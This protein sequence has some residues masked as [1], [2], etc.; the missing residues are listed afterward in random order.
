MIFN[1]DDKR[2]RSTRLFDIGCRT[3]SSKDNRM[4]PKA[5]HV[6][7]C[8]SLATLPLPTRATIKCLIVLIPDIQLL[9]F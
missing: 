3:K 2:A 6:Q 7:L 9:P 8:G 4:K 1:W 5:Y